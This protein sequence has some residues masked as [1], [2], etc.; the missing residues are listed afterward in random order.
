MYF[1]KYRVDYPAPATPQ[2]SRKPKSP[3]YTF[4]LLYTKNPKCKNVEAEKSGLKQKVIQIDLSKLSID[5]I[6]HFYGP[7]VVRYA[8]NIH[9]RSPLGR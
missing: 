1:T 6:L 8:S 3:Q 5:R 9:H 2:H 4:F 7:Y